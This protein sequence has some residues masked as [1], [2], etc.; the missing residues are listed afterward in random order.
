METVVPAGG[1]RGLVGRGG[2]C[3]APGRG[4]KRR[5]DYG[6]QER[7][8]L[9]AG[10]RIAFG[11][12]EF[13]ARRAPLEVSETSPRSPDDIRRSRW[14]YGLALALYAGAVLSK[15]VTASAP[16]VL[17]VIYWW[18]R[19]RVTLRDV[20]PLLPMFVLGFSL[21]MITVWMERSTVG[22]VGADWALSPVDRF[23][24]AGRAVW[25][26]AGKLLWPAPL[27]FFYERWEL[28]PR[29]FWQFA[30]PLAAVGVLVALWLA[31]GR[32]GRGPL[33]AVLI[34]CGVLFPALGFINVFPFRFSFVADHFQYHAS[35]ALIAPGCATA[36]MAGKG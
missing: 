12:F 28:Q 26:Y 4:G 18:K 5:L 31:R 2:V 19:G 25:F 14:N 17:L 27:I 33:A 15:T 9:R 22:A 21:A 7:I 3:G 24:I 20:R 36:T 8:V 11:V 13:F 32:I 1:T 35:I 34:F 23:L 10:D 29:D 6:T 16:A 30:Y